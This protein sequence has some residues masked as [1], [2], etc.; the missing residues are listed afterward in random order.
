MANIH[1]P[2]MDAHLTHPDA[3]EKPLHQLPHEKDGGEEPRRSDSVP[4]IRVSKDANLP[5]PPK[6]HSLKKPRKKKKVKR[7]SYRFSSHC[8][9]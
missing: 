9:G 4:Y 6:N 8:G 5:R 3:S 1:S 2:L 7:V